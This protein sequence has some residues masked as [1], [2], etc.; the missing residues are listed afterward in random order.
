MKRT[1]GFS[2]GLILGLGLWLFGTAAADDE[3]RLVI[4]DHRFSPS[5]VRVKADTKIKLIV[6]NEDPTAEE[7]ES[8]S[9]NREKVVRPGQSITVL[10]PPLKPGIYD[11][12]GE[13]HPD[14]ATGK[15]IAE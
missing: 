6:T 4:K 8:S 9:L 11:F 12:Y 5:E 10:L 14:T 1:T 3:I 13:F 15:I 7:F 2:I